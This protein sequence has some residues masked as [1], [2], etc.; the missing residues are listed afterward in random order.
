M[1]HIWVHGLIGVHF[2]ES[3][4]KLFRSRR[5]WSCIHRAF[6]PLCLTF[7]LKTNR[8]MIFKLDTA[9][10]RTNANESLLNCSLFDQWERESRFVGTIPITNTVN[11]NNHG[12]IWGPVK[13]F[14]QI[15]Q[16]S[17][18]MIKTKLAFDGFL[19]F[20]YIYYN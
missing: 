18:Y 5:R 7:D 16:N 17:F 10:I 15:K 14:S 6:E 11:V 13:S 1:C 9:G 20:I 19:L 4:R 3:N 8:K 2:F 12:A